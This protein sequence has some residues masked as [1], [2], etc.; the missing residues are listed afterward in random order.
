MGLGSKIKSAFKSAEQKVS[1]VVT[2]VATAPAD[3][4][5]KQV[6]ALAPVIDQVGGIV[7]RN[8]ALASAAGAVAGVPFLSGIF[9]GGGAATPAQA[10]PPTIAAQPEKAPAPAWLWPAVIVG[11]ALVLVLLLRKK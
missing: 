1:N 7:Q 5:G 10:N 6:S 8:P 9:G 11:G 4:L 2:K 3:L